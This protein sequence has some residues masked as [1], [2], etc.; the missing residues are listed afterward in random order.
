[1]MSL[2][3]DEHVEGKNV[4]YQ[5]HDSGGVVYVSPAL[6]HRRAGDPNFL[7]LAPTCPLCEAKVLANAERLGKIDE[8]LAWRAEETQRALNDA[9]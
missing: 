9:E 6:A 8:F 5:L 1:M 3:R 7:S 4:G 2:D